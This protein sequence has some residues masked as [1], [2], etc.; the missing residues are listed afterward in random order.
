VIGSD[1]PIIDHTDPIC[2]KLLDLTPT[3]SPL[4]PTIPS[5]LHAYHKS[6][7]DIR[8]YNPSF[9]PYCADL[10]DVPRKIMWNT[11]FDDA[12]DFSIVVDEFK[13]PLTLFASSSP[14]FSYLHNF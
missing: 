1:A 10:E 5:H 6:L 4:L 7:S 11:F 8:G 13:R 14:V 2:S 3:S 12:F 9:D